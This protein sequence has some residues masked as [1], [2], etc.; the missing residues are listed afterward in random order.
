[1]GVTGGSLVDARLEVPIDF[2]IAHKVIEMDIALQGPNGAYKLVNPANLDE[3][4]YRES[5]L[6]RVF[7]DTTVSISEQ[8]R[9]DIA[10]Q[11]I[12]RSYFPGNDHD[13]NS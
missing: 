3:R 11:T 5:R 2:S 12:W 8:L 6:Y 1:M 7:V 13:N 4:L 10:F 9:F